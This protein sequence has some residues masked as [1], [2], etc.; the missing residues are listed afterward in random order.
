[1]D[2]SATPSQEWHDFCSLE[3]IPDGGAL[4]R[5]QDGE[6]LMVCRNGP[7]VTCMPNY[8]PHRGWPFLGGTV[9][10]GVL[11]CPFHGCEF[12]LAAGECLTSPGLPLDRYRAFALAR[13][14]SS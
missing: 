3:E 1:M 5:V 14:R 10:S 11:T 12:R 7:E 13:S 9:R 6:D 2:E 4:T 8:C